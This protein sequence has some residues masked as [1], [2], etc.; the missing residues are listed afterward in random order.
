MEMVL[1]VAVRDIGQLTDL[2]RELLAA[3]ETTGRSEKKLLKGTPGE[4][5]KGAQD[6][7]WPGRA[8]PGGP[9]LNEVNL[10]FHPAETR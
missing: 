6:A 3:A 5:W 7:P 9:A 4:P 10:R 2:A 1:Q 8:L